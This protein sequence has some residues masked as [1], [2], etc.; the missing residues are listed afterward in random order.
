MVTTAP[1]ISVSL[2][3]PVM[4]YAFTMPPTVYVGSTGWI[5]VSSIVPVTAAYLP[6]AGVNTHSAV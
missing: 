4:L 6:L 2:P 3:L 5:T 1:L